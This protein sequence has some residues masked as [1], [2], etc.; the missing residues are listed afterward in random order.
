M[1]Q[2]S[3]IKDNYLKEEIRKLKVVEEE[4]RSKRSFIA[5]YGKTEEELDHRLRQVREAG[6]SLLGLQK[7]E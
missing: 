5:I 3:Q 1:R 4:F 7:L 6:G 2:L